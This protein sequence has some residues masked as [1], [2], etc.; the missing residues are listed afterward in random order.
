M[1]LHRPSPLAHAMNFGLFHLKTQIQRGQIDDGGYS[2][3]SLTPYP[4]YNDV[5]IHVFCFLQPSV[6]T[7]ASK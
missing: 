5:L 2:Q 6:R 4:G 7:H 3:D 1:R